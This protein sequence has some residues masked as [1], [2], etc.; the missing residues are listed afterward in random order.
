MKIDLPALNLLGL[1][2]NDMFKFYEL[3]PRGQVA[4][5][6]KAQ[7]DFLY[8]LNNDEGSRLND[9]NI[10]LPKHVVKRN[11][12]SKGNKVQLNYSKFLRLRKA[13]YSAMDP[14]STPGDTRDK[15]YSINAVY[16]Y[17]GSTARVLGFYINT[18]VG[19]ELDMSFKAVPV[20]QDYYW[21]NNAWANNSYHIPGITNKLN[22]PISL[23]NLLAN[24]KTANTTNLEL[25]GK[26]D[27]IIHTTTRIL[28]GHKFTIIT[29]LKPSNI[30]AYSYRG[31]ATMDM[32]K[33]PL[34]F[35]F[36]NFYNRLGLNG[37][38]YLNTLSTI[39]LSN[40]LDS[41]VNYILIAN[42][43]TLKSLNAKIRLISQWFTESPSVSSAYFDYTIKAKLYVHIDDL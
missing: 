13:Y 2:T 32:I 22:I 3:Y 38:E 16:H 29:V 5:E 10:V 42:P 18:E 17:S 41:F 1:T 40:G 25:L 8:E 21:A 11:V 27:P 6:T 36:N 39:N 28:L 35:E 15:F 14:H 7:L 34:I 19:S 4:L 20:D 23:D 43:G 12:L 24:I 26:V 33:Q 9:H 30:T 37:K 31:D